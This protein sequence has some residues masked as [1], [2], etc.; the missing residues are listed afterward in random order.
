M[1]VAIDD[2]AAQPGA[3]QDHHEDQASSPPSPAHRGGG[4]HRADFLFNISAIPSPSERKRD[5][6]LRDR[7]P[8]QR[9]AAV[10]HPF[11]TCRAA[12]PASEGRRARA[13]CLPSRHLGVSA[14]QRSGSAAA[15]SA[16]RCSLLLRSPRIGPETSSTVCSTPSFAS[17]WRRSRQ[18]TGRTAPACPGSWRT[19]F[20]RSSGAAAK[21]AMMMIPRHRRATASVPPA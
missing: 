17:T 13:R 4:R 16:G 19:S 21:F 9:P 20:G 7:P 11:L 6:H 15:R 8:Q 3:H 2:T 12:S 1:L 18:P 14:D 5:S 10:R